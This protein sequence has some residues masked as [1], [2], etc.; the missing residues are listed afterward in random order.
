M[1]SVLCDI[2]PCRSVKCNLRF[3]GTHLPLF[4]VE[5]CCMLHA[6]FLHVLLF[7]PEDVH[8]CEIQSTFRRNILQSYSG[9]KLAV[10][11]MLGFLFALDMDGICSS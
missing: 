2:A 3:G 6:I 4:R 9:S 1:S 5:A 7:D 8:I 11:F 10:C